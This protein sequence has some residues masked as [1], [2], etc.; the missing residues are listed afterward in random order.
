[1]VYFDFVLKPLD[2]GPIQLVTQSEVVGILHEVRAIFHD[3]ESL[4][5]DLEETEYDT[6]G[7]M[8]ILVFSLLQ[9]R[10]VLLAEGLENFE[11]AF[12]DLL[13]QELAIVGHVERKTGL[14]D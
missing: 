8:S 11:F 3:E 14:P 9:I 6:E 1:M 10:E 12:G 2:Q 5:L 7:R 13:D 4:S